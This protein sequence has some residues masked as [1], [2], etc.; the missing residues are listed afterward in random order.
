[1]QAGA[2]INFNLI[3]FQDPPFSKGKVNISQSGGKDEDR[4]LLQMQRK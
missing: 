1:M 3:F 2:Y 4:H